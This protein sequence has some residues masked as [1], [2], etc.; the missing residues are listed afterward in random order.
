MEKVDLSN[1]LRDERKTAEFQKLDKNFYE[2]VGLYL[3][4]LE[5]ELSK[6]TDPYS[7]EAQI[8][9]DTLKGERNSVN[10]LIDQRMRKMVRRVVKNAR[11]ASREDVLLDLTSEEEQIY[12]QMLSAVVTGRET[13]QA[14]I[15]HTERPLTGKKDIPQGYEIVRLLDSVP[16]FVGVDGKNYLLTKD[17]VVMLPGVHAKNL[18]TKNLAVEVKIEQ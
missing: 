3:A 1:T 7:V 2:Q 5:Q 11:S 10:K 13:I 16:M 4:G 12:T 15:A 18:R 6:I 8:I 9:Q 17:D 14:H